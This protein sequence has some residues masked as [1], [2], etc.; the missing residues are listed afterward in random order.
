MKKLVSRTRLSVAIALAAAGVASPNIAAAEPSYTLEEVTVT[1]RKRAESVQ[2]VPIAMAA[3]GGDKLEDLGVS[4]I[5]ELQAQVPNLTAYPAR[6]TTSTL[7]TYIRGVGQSDPLWGVD[8]GV[9][10]YFDDV[11]VARPQGA[12][13]D[14]FDVERVEVLRGPQ[15][16]LYGKNTIGGA[17][18]YVSK[19]IDH[20]RTGKFSL[21][22]GD[23]GQQEAK[24][25]VQL[26]LIDDT[27]TVKV[28]GASLVRRDGFG[29]NRNTGSDHVSDKEIYSGRVALQW[30][31]TDSFSA[32]F[33][34]D[35]TVDRSAPIGAQVLASNPVTLAYDLTGT[36]GLAGGD[37]FDTNSGFDNKNDTETQGYSLTLVADL[38]DEFTL[39][40]ITGYRKGATDTYI[41]F[42]TTPFPITDVRAIYEDDQLTQEIQLNYSGEKLELVTGLYFMTGEAGGWVANEFFG[43]GVLG[44]PANGCVCGTTAGVVDTDSVSIYGQGTYA[45]NDRLSFTLGGRLTV[46]EK[47]VVALN[48]G[49]ADNT[50]STPVSVASDFSDSKT[51]REFSPRIG[52]D[53]QFSDDVMVYASY[54]EGFKSGGFNVRA[55]TQAVPESGN[56]YDPETVSSFEIGAKSTLLD[57]RITLN[58]A[59]FLND[60]EDIQLSVF[61]ALPDSTFFGDFTNAGKA[62]ING[63]EIDFTMAL[64][65]SVTL[66]ASYGYLDA[67]YDEYVDAGVDI[68]DA[69]NL[70][71]AP[72]NTF[73]IGI[74]Y[75]GSLGDM[76]E[77]MARVDYAWRD[78]SVLTTETN[79]AAARAVADTGPGGANASGILT[80]DNTRPL[81]ADSYGI[82][83]ATVNWMPDE[84]WR[85]GLSV[86]NLTDEEY[87][88]T[89]YNFYTTGLKVRTGFYGA[90]RTWSLSASYNF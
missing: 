19:R 50:F 64:S 36:T 33:S 44:G 89:G 21:V 88:V 56:P 40:S 6:G 54:S 34:A 84:N 65:E 53:Y 63:L 31:P 32:T 18:K 12:L 46:E 81:K 28:S 17:I 90:P 20:Q 77:I 4:S 67:D 5:N 79:T 35:Y 86:K 8:P 47:E 76:G 23:Y 7:T 25:D 52:F 60:Y 69:E 73:N 58:G 78:E 29:E 38:S 30:D 82:V 26:P 74:Q 66:N 83:N 1:A 37:E 51:F 49:F 22:Y 57:G 48:Q 75:D 42:D 16:T 27:L 62:T 14:V 59:L 39:K 10:L 13:L 55:N 24:G 70:T 41:D 87:L 80:L 68:A 9:G 43:D 72:E 85:F 45:L 2:D 61:T 71:N 11:Y 3:F 15:G